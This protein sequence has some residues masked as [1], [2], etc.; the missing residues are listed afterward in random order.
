[1]KILVE[2]NASGDTYIIKFIYAGI[3]FYAPLEQQ[4]DLS[5]SV[6]LLE[7]PIADLMNLC[8]QELKDIKQQ[9]L[10]KHEAE[11]GSIKFYGVDYS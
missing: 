2:Y 6:E 8:I 3:Q 5:L 1:M 10:A 4:G 9:K 11:E 7:K